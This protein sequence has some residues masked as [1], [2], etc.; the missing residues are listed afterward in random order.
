M[1]SQP[2]LELACAAAGERAVPFPS[3]ADGRERRGG[4]RAAQPGVGDALLA[5]GR[6]ANVGVT[7][8]NGVTC[9]AD[10]AEPGGEGDDVKVLLNLVEHTACELLAHNL[11]LAR[12]RL[13]PR[14]QPVS[15][16]PIMSLSAFFYS[17]SAPLMPSQ[18]R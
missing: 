4:Y 8:H 3:G 18:A 13:P 10:P 11:L 2:T 14:C 7:E 12:R 17:L 15:A 1:K 16:L 6:A 5:S 9:L